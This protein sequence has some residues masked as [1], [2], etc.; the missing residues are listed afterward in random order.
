MRLEDN[1][2]QTKHLKRKLMPLTD[3][4][5]VIPEYTNIA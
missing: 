3:V 1:V 2:R 4:D 5:I